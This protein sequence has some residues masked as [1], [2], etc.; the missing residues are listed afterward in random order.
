MTQPTIW[1][2]TPHTAAKHQ[3]LREYLK[4]WFPILG[5]SRNRILF[6]DG[7]AGPGV[8]AGGEKGSSV[9]ALEALLDRGDL[10]RLSQCEFIFV[11][12][13][14]DPERYQS[15]VKVEGE[16]KARRGGYPSNVRV[17]LHNRFF[18]ELVD[19]ART[20]LE[21]Q[22]ARRAPTFAFVDPFGYKDVDLKKIADL[23]NYEGCELLIYFDFNSVNR[24]STSGQVDAAF[25]Q[26]FGTD[27]FASAPLA[28]DPD[29]RAAY[30]TDLF[31]QQLNTVGRFPYVQRFRMTGEQD[32]TICYLFYCTRNLKGLKVMKRA[33]WSVA[34][35][36]NY[37]FTDKL[38]GH[39]VLFE[40]EPDMSPLREALLGKF[41]GSGAPIEAIEEFTLVHT[42]YHDGHIKKATLVPMQNEGLI[43]SPNQKRKNTYPPGTIIVFS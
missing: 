20:Q 40:P 41:A 29:R 25:Q 36:G 22:H 34:P 28:G 38:A 19:G 14:S 17:E 27:K 21:Q 7:F 42:P 33:M 5:Q 32:R 35:T 26:L 24:F 39:D 8:Y 6:L 1:P 15:L 23:L 3:I 30:L 13:E 4:A 10:S 31:E 11:F 37:R 16:L 2:I 12:N 9:V 43:S 18:G